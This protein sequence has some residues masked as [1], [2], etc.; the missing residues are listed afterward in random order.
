M[1]LRSKCEINKRK[2]AN[3]KT[4]AN[5][6]SLAVNTLKNESYHLGAGLITATIFFMITSSVVYSVVALVW[7]LF[8]DTDHL[9][10]YIYYLIKNKIKFSLKEFLSGT[11]IR[12]LGKFTAP[13]HS[14]ELWLVILIAG[15]TNE[16]PILII[17]STTTLIHLTVDSFTNC[18]NARFYFLTYRLINKF[19]TKTIL[20]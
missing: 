20:S 9:P 19:D 15:F 14:W 18:V 4:D 2:S 12:K 16:L 1:Q 11:Y 10:D 5:I 8:I 7:S 6:L 17:I 13:L 3:H